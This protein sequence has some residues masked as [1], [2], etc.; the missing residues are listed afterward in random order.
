MEL[1]CLE[2]R[3][4]EGDLPQPVAEDGERDDHKVRTR[5]PL[6]ER[7]GR[8]QRDALQRLAEAHLIGEDAVLLTAVHGEQPVETLQLSTRRHNL[9]FRG[10]G[11]RTGE[12]RTRARARLAKL[13][14]ARA[15]VG[16]AADA[17]PAP[18]PSAVP[19]YA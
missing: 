4:P 13:R 10:H 2:L 12:R 5:E 19:Y 6:L 14:C 9:F 16:A 17:E 11:Q 3:A 15:A 8:E 7:Q 1:V 18:V